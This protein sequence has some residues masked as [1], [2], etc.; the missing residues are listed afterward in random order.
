M[1]VMSD[2]YF[3]EEEAKRLKGA[4]LRTNRAFSG[5]PEGKEGIVTDIDSYGDD[6]WTIGLTWRTNNGN[7]ITDWFSKTEYIKYLYGK[8]PVQEVEEA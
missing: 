6:E 7:R 3:T 2:D 4:R 5:I 8:P 1:I